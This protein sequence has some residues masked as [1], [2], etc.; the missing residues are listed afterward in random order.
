MKIILQDGAVMLA[1]SKDAIMQ[2]P[3]LKIL[4]PSCSMT[5]NA[6][7]ISAKIAST[8][9]NKIETITHLF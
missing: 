2:K 6:I 1:I 9:T 8:H 5:L 3:V 7:L 4:M